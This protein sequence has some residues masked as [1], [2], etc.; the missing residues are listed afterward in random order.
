MPPVTFRS[1]Q[2]DF[3]SSLS[4]G[5][6]PTANQKPAFAG[7]ATSVDPTDT[8]VLSAIGKSKIVDQRTFF[9]GQSKFPSVRSTLASGI[10]NVATSLT[11]AAGDG[12]FFQKYD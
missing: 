7:W 11:T 1:A 9:W 3:P 4:G 6:V 10:T 12:V 2:N 8:P 5:T